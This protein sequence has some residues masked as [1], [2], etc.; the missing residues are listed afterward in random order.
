MNWT[1]A[2]VIVAII[3]ALFKAGQFI[4]NKVFKFGELANRLSSVEKTVTEI[5]KETKDLGVGVS[6]ILKM[7]AK[8]GL[9]VSQSPSVLSDEGKK[10]VASSGIDEIVN[11]KF[12][13]IVKKVKESKPENPYQAQETVFNIVDGFK[14][15]ASL[16][17]ALEKGAFNSGYRVVS[18]LYA[19]GLYIRDRVLEEI[20]M[21]PDEID[22]H[23]PKET[24][25]TKK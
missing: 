17:D 7:L 24:S 3:I 22:K 9:S 18:V 4:L 11:D 21:K 13:F 12:D 23:D 25:K 16:K 20:G 19:G 15:D 1:E 6:D 8:K 14:N 10:V 5:K 2:A